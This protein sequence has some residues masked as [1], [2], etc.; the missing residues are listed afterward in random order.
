M[1]ALHG[2][3]DPANL[4]SLSEKE[5]LLRAMAEYPGD[6]RSEGCAVRHAMDKPL[7]LA[8]AGQ[9]AG[10]VFFDDHDFLCAVAG[11]IFSSTPEAHF[12]KNLAPDELNTLEGSFALVRHTPD[13][14]LMLAC[15]FFGSNPVYW[16]ENGGLLAFSTSLRA[17]WTLPFFDATVDMDAVAEYLS[18]G[19]IAA[20]RTIYASVKKIPA[21]HWLRASGHAA[22]LHR[23]GAFTP[24]L[25]IADARA[26][27]ELNE[28]L[29]SL[30]QR[31][32][33]FCPDK[34]RSLAPFQKSSL[35]AR[36]V[37]TAAGD[38]LCGA[39]TLD[40]SAMPAADLDVAAVLDFAG[41]VLSEPNAAAFCL[42][43]FLEPS[44]VPE[45]H[46]LFTEIGGEELLG[47]PRYR[48]YTASDMPRRSLGALHY[49]DQTMIFDESAIRELFSL[50]PEQTQDRIE[51]LRLSLVNAAWLSPLHTVR[52][53]DMANRIPAMLQVIADAGAASGIRMLSPF[54]TPAVARFAEKLPLAALLRNIQVDHAAQARSEPEVRTSALSGNGLCRAPALSET[55]KSRLREL[56]S[57][58]AEQGAALAKIFPAQTLRQLREKIAIYNEKRLWTLC[59]LASFLRQAPV[60]AL[61][62]PCAREEAC[63]PAVPVVEAARQSLLHEVCKRIACPVMCLALSNLHNTP[64]LLGMDGHIVMGDPP[65]WMPEAVVFDWERESSWQ[66]LAPLVRPGMIACFSNGMI[67]DYALRK[68]L[69]SIGIERVLL[70]EDDRAYFL[71]TRTPTWREQLRNMWTLFRM[72]RGKA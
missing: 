36:I 32:M 24:G 64:E 38:D 65:A 21:A 44:P 7:C 30:L 67:P 51:K 29:R 18:L 69:L 43:A 37:A 3:F 68:K 15:D 6:E 72:A 50:F 1:N 71:P 34:K 56:A 48:P 52:R 59:V 39:A 45:E 20:P 25:P 62:P 14:G 47:S 57:E 28:E 5:R 33:S 46:L 17:L 31:N 53:A 8:C 42:Q 61:L 26:P 27:E 22:S 40:G 4:F 70:L 2:I 12:F 55:Q 35:A 9:G 54:L 11:N 19:A 58:A 13:Q 41:K 10:S 23:Y 66:A 60:S 49:G 16:T 63:D